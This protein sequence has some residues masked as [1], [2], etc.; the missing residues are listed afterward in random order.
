MGKVKSSDEQHARFLEAARVAG[1]D[2]DT[3]AADRLMGRLAKTKPEPK[4]ASRQ[5]KTPSPPIQN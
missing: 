2:V 5:K 3:D 1:A 4:A